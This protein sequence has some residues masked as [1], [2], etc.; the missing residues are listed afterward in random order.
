MLVV[1]VYQS[2]QIPMFLQNLMLSCGAALTLTIL[3]RAAVYLKRICNARNSKEVLRE[4]EIDTTRVRF[5][6]D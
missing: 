4:V 1:L 3:V 6:P 2:V 5:A